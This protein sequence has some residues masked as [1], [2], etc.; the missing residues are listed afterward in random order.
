MDDS[1]IFVKISIRE[2][3]GAAKTYLNKVFL[4][5][6]APKEILHEESR[7]IAE[8]SNFLVRKDHDIFKESNNFK[9]SN[10][11]NNFTGQ[12]KNEESNIFNKK[13]E[14]D[15]LAKYLPPNQ[16][17]SSEKNKF[18]L[19]NSA[20]NSN[21]KYPNSSKNTAT[22][23]FANNDIAEKNN[24]ETNWKANNI[25][26]YYDK[27]LNLKAEAQKIQPQSEIEEDNN[28]NNNWLP[29]KE[30]KDEKKTEDEIKMLKEEFSK[31][32]QKFIKMQENMEFLIEKQLEMHSSLE[33]FKEELFTNKTQTE[34]RNLFE[35]KAEVNYFFFFFFFFKN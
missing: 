27:F 5:S 35:K 25:L 13:E 3:F 20:N 31:F 29:L 1:Y 30:E 8:E 11:F 34:E 23:F 18:F 26:K 16:P 6:E 24:T 4:L 33:G 21:K 2:T 12:K 19:F 32:D 14:D 28:N 22:K 15:I 17:I 7:E 10:N 9:K